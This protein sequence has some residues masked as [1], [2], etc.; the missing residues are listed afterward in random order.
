MEP[1]IESRTPVV[2]RPA[3][4]ARFAAFVAERFPFALERATKAFES[5]CQ[6]DPGREPAAL[7]ALRRPLSEALARGLDGAA[8][9]G[10]PD[11]TPRVSAADRLR[12]ARADL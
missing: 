6:A 3:L 10:I 1:M 2:S 4:V 8:P 11:P 7:E 5:V 12:K 9:E